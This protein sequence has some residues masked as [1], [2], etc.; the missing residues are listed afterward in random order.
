MNNDRSGKVKKYIYRLFIAGVI[1]ALSGIITLA[2]IFYYLSYDLPPVGPLR[3]GYDPPQSTRILA[4]DKTLIGEIYDERRRVVPISEIP[5]ILKNA[6]ISAEDAEFKTHGGI[7]YMGIIRAALKNIIHGH[8]AQ[9]ASTITQQVARTFFLTREKSLK[10]KIKEMLLTKKIEDELSKDDILFLYLNQINFGHARYG[11]EEASFY[12]F[13]KRVKDLTLP[14]AAL[15]AGIPKGPSIF[16]PIGHVEKAKSRRSYV[17]SMLE[18]NGYISHA[19]AELA[20][21]APLGLKENHFNRVQYVPEVMQMIVSELKYVVDE[22]TLKH[23]GYTII[24]SLD[25]KLQEEV[26]ESVS[27]GL[28]AIDKRHQRVAPFKKRDWPKK[29]DRGEGNIYRGN[30]YIARVTGSDDKT[31]IVK[32]KLGDR[33]SIIYLKNEKRYN[34]E[35]LKGS[36]FA[37]IDSK[38]RVK[39]I[40]DPKATPL[41]LSLAVGPQAAA[42]VIDVKT[43]YI[44]AIA[45]G[46]RVVPGGFNRAVLS[47]R[48]PGSAFKPFVYLQALRSRKFTAATLLDDSPEVEGDWK[49]SDSHK[50]DLKGQVTMRDALAKSLNL[51]AVKLIRAVGPENVVEL[52]RE[53]G[54]NSKLEALPSLALGVCGVTPL[55]L[56]AAYATLAAE[57][58]KR[59]P[60]IVKK[61]YKNNNNIIPLVGKIG[62]PVIPRDEAY[63]ITSMLQSVITDGT[64]YKAKSLKLQ[65]AG[66]TGTTDDAVDAWF[67]GYSPLYATTVWVGYDEPRSIGKKEYGAKAA[68][69]IW[70]DIMKYAH[71]DTK[72]NDFKMP[73]GVISVSID[74]ATG[75][76]P[77]DGMD[78]PGEEIFIEG[79]QPEEK[80]LPPDVVSI[81]NFMVEQV[82]EDSPKETEK[83]RDTD[84]QGP[85]T[86]ESIENNI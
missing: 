31:G 74:P 83:N 33:D 39:L 84:S 16:E 51:P 22:K 75:L 30:V 80:A 85:Q 6:V 52:A 61:I 59:G 42:V 1:I 72:V 26:R 14:E 41:K 56:T 23:G 79:T 67:A 10:R 45:G 82:I 78:K 11:V 24:T 5:D 65:L 55:E 60:F 15:I 12:Y 19:S 3:D 9:G 63:V 77:Y 73:P 68:L 53:L 70:I 58:I 48:Q 66:K 81:D 57:G 18:K 13:D 62:K 35:N 28:T 32:L 34:P 49:P 29:E 2:S 44:K 25:M 21:E 46:D 64:A 27:K 54:I 17:L 7:D 36:Q 40:S 69:P 71:K 47:S 76:L 38:L 4:A 8:M 43:G 20:K 86:A 37:E 50:D